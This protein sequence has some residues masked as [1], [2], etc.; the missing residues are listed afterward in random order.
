MAENNGFM[1]IETSAFGSD[2]V[3]TA[4]EEL[5]NAVSD[6]RQTMIK[7]GKNPMEHSRAVLK[8]HDPEL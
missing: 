7:A 4:F 3:T 8:L 5:M 2:N 1:F 6:V